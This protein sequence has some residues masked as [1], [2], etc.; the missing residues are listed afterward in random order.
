MQ[1]RIQ[2]VLAQAGLGS[3]RQIEAWVSAG[4]VTVDGKPAV[5]GQKVSGRE[6]IR[7]DGRPVRVR[8]VHR[9]APEVLVYHKPSGEVCSR[10][11]PEG[12]PTVFASLPRPRQGRWIGVGRL[13]IS[14][15]GLLLLTND[16]ELANRLMHP[17]QEIER[18]YAVRLLGQVDRP[19][20]ERLLK[21]VQLE[22]GFGRF[23]S[24]EEAGG[25]GANRWF[26]VVI[27]E[28]RNREV[29]RLWESQGVRV[30][31][32]T[33]VRFGPVALERGLRQGRWRPL[34]PKE[35]KQLYQAAGLK[36]PRTDEGHRKRISRERRKR[37]GREGR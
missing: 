33:R 7:V 26:H 5:L 14:T 8:E 4:R 1:D 27:R 6:R 22:D 20:L 37:S 12:R 17:A 31:R 2:K 3:R 32:L 21:G 25:S 11:D 9:E 16:G 35:L 19:M 18:E 28:G 23:L 36:P 30:S 24:I 13:D 15:T 10:D 34:S 29:R